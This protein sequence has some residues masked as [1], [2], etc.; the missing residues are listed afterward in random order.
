[1][2]G[3]SKFFNASRN[4]DLETVQQILARNR[5]DVNEESI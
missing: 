4:G 2:S 5:I 1:M 3:A